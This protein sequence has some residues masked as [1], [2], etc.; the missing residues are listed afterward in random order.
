M[1]QIIFLTLL[2]LM[3]VP[4]YGYVR[5]TFDLSGT[6][7]PTFWRS[8][9]IP[10][11]WTTY[12]NGS[13]DVPFSAMMRAL[14]NSF[15]VWENLSYANISTSY[16]GN[17]T[18][19]NVGND[20]VNLIA[21]DEDGSFL[22]QGAST[23]ATTQFFVSVS[24]GRL[25]DADI[26]FN[27]KSFTFATGGADY[28]IESI[29]MH[30]IGHFFGLDHAVIGS[31][32][33][34][35]KRP[36]MTPFYIGINGRTLEQDDRAGLG[37]TYPSATF[38][39]VTGNVS[40]N[41]RNGTQEI[42][43]AQIAALNA[44]T[45]VPAVAVL[46]GYRTG[47]GA[48]GQGDYLMLG[49]E[50]GNYTI[51]ATPMDGS[52]G[53]TSSNFNGI[54]SDTFVTSF[55]TQ[56]HPNVFN[57]SQARNVTI[58]P[59]SLTL[60]SFVGTLYNVNIS[61][62][63]D[64]TI[65][66][67]TNATYAVLVGNT[68][69][70]RDTLTLALAA[71]GT[72][73]SLNQSAF[74]SVPEG[75][76][77]TALVTVS[78]SAPGTY[79]V[80]VNVTSQGNAS[81]TAAINV[82]TTVLETVAATAI[83]PAS[84]ALVTSPVSF[85]CNATGA[86]LQ[87]L[88][89]FTNQSGFTGASTQNVSGTRNQ[90]TF[91][92]SL[93]DSSYIWTCLANDTM[94]NAAFAA[95]RT[96]TV[97]STAPLL[98]LNVNATRLEMNQEFLLISWASQDA[99]L[100][101]PFVNVSYPNGTLFNRTENA[102]GAL[103]VSPGQLGTYTIDLVAND[104]VGNRNATRTT[105]TVVDTS[106]P[107]VTLL[108]PVNGSVT[109]ANTTT[110]SCNATDVT[111]LATLALFHNG[112]GTFAQN[113]SVSV[114]GARNNVT[115]TIG[116]PE[117]QLLWNCKATDINGNASFASANFSLITDHSAPRVHSIVLNDDYVSPNG[118][119]VMVVNA[120]DTL[121]DIANVTAN[122]SLLQASGAIFNRTFNGSSQAGRHVVAVLATDE[123]GNSVSN[124]TTY[125]VDAISPAI[126]IYLPP[127]T[128]FS[129]DGNVTL[130]WQVTDDNI[131]STNITV[132]TTTQVGVVNKTL[133]AHNFSQ[134]FS[135]L[136]SGSHAVIIAA[137]DNA[138]RST[139]L[140]YNFTLSRPENVTDLINRLRTAG[141]FQNIVYRQPNGSILSGNILLNQTLVKDFI[142]NASLANI[143]I[144]ITAFGEHFDESKASLIRLQ[145]NRTGVF[146]LAAGL[147]LSGRPPSQ[148]ILFQNMSQY[149]PDNNYSFQ[150]GT[151]TF[152]TINFNGELGRLVPFYVVDDDG[153]DVRLLGQCTNNTAPT[154]EPS[155]STMCY[156]NSSTAVT[157]YVPHLSGGGLDD[158]ANAP[159]INITSPQDRSN[160][161][162]FT[163]TGQVLDL[164]LG[165]CTYNLTNTT[166]TLVSPT[167]FSPSL[168]GVNTSNYTFSIDNAGFTGLANG[169]RYNLTVSCSSTDGNTTTVVSSFQVND[170][171]P[172]RTT[173]ITTSGATSVTSSGTLSALFTTHE[174]ATCGYNS[175][176]P[177]AVLTSF[178]QANTNLSSS[179][180][181]TIHTYSTTYTADGTVT[182]PAVICIDVNGNS[183]SRANDSFG[184]AVNVQEP[185]ASSSSGGGGGG[186]A[187]PKTTGPIKIV[188]KMAHIQQGQAVTVSFIAKEI[189]LTKIEFIA[190]E[191][192]SN[193]ELSVSTA[194]K[195]VTIPE[196]PGLVYQYIT[197]T[198]APEGKVKNA[199]LDFRLAKEWVDANKLDDK[200]IVL[201]LFDGQWQPL[202]TVSTGSSD[203]QVTFRAQTPHLSWFAI[204]GPQEEEVP[205]EVS[206]K[207]QSEETQLEPPQQEAV[208]QPVNVSTSGEVQ[209]VS[210]IEGQSWVWWISGFFI[211]VLFGAFLAWWHFRNPE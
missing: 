81:A 72:N 188:K 193:L 144:N 125:V 22:S 97:D 139:I 65:F 94:G 105:F 37:A 28:D 208:Q 19:T 100:G 11:Q 143:T 119:I 207:E 168:V 124:V 182:V 77:R 194:A 211:L 95:N 92:V 169:S 26:I 6:V 40:G 165:S 175:S 24:T 14:N 206:T 199:A 59:N 121:T 160:D 138:S 34:T 159:T 36:T 21:F 134:V 15:A 51:K 151:K 164:N 23:L 127:R 102:S 186:K 1:K 27:G 13:A 171:I 48:T 209:E 46:T 62:S 33:S 183:Q 181:G 20:A 31:E 123:V 4:S 148:F 98:S 60:S 152:A 197:I 115:V 7:I 82:T 104:T 130:L 177:T 16:Q 198:S 90:S 43:G 67:G 149:I 55:R 42:F 205:V 114:T 103:A 133:S 118:T 35:D 10:V 76:V 154:T 112:Q 29:A 86:S 108:A 12:L 200:T 180:A 111:G 38:F 63:A 158:P 50:P 45:G 195:P 141:G 166:S 8:A 18:S 87:S 39:N 173:A 78:A 174:Y 132:D 2:L 71:D 93:T 96:V 191:A 163:A 176:V 53:I 85:V 187:T 47:S 113:E 172:P 89:L 147:R 32:V 66:N 110:F 135:D 136:R 80:R 128:F 145:L 58:A 192:I 142:T 156:T 122:G 25:L 179:S 129:Q 84:S 83:S 150:N 3:A 30:E 155:L 101:S 64:Q 210:L 153:A 17:T 52:N 56:Y 88:T 185:S 196:F 178:S 106:A 57:Q 61:A 117:A 49:L 41:V 189:A 203:V 170:I 120:T 9:D 162:A 146:G 99:H 68:G 75:Q 54:F 116:V 126:S 184:V 69:N 74:A 140:R 161:T 157:L 73:A 70:D 109:G 91:N 131:S 201:Y 79:T 167:S 190:S 5:A 137:G 107:L 202:P 204:A 44:T